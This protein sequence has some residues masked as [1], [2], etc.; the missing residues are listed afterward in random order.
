LKNFF[1]SNNI[2]STLINV[3]NHNK[4]EIRHLFQKLANEEK[5]NLKQIDEVFSSMENETSVH[6]KDYSDDEKLCFYL[7]FFNLKLLHEMLFNRLTNE[8]KTFP[9]NSKE[10]MEFLS[11]V[12]FRLFGLNLN[13][14]EFDSTIIRYHILNCFII[15]TKNSG[16]N[17]MLII[18]LYQWLASSQNSLD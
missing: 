9:K 11:S 18:Y 2:L 5:Y 12:K 16:K 14:W 6:H 17:S 13:L 7:N 15:K 4:I 10:W 8:S 3:T 1:R